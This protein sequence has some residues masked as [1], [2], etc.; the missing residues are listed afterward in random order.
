[1]T[2]IHRR[3][4]FGPELTQFA[5]AL[6]V[7]AGLLLLPEPVSSDHD[8]LREKLAPVCGAS[9]DTPQDH[10]WTT[11]AAVN[12]PDSCDDEDDDDEGDDDSSGSSSQAIAATQRIAAN[13]NDALRIVHADR[14]AHTFHPLDA[15]SLR[16]PPSGQKESSDADVDDDDDD[17]NVGAHHAAPRAA[18]DRKPH[19]LSGVDTFHPASTG[20]SQALRAPPQ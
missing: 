12:A 19:A 17:D 1:L 4:F 3:S 5:S 11:G 14:D 6:L 7:C 18:A 16:S 8:E 2:T 9:A 10:Q 15:H 20:S 13:H